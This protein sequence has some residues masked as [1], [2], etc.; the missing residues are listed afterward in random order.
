MSQV[1]HR[2]GG[3]PGFL[4][5]KRLRVFLL[6]SGWYASRLQGYPQHYTWV[7]RIYCESVLLNNIMQCPRP[8][9]EPGPLDPET[10]ALTMRSPH[11]PCRKEL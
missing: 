8:A 11:L 6:P 1:A 3:Y 10:S 9:L 2:T 4:S 5:I 7:E